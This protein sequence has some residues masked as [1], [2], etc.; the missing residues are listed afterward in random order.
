MIAE[1]FYPETL[2]YMLTHNI[3]LEQEIIGREEKALV[4]MPEK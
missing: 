1:G 4:K 2:Q 3:K